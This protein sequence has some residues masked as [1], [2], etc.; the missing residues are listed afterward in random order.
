MKKLF[1]PSW[2]LLALA[3]FNGQTFAAGSINPGR[4]IQGFSYNSDGTGPASGVSIASPAHL[5]TQLPQAGQI[6]GRNVIVNGGSEVA[7]INGTTLITPT[8][9]GYPIDNIMFESTTAGVFQSVKVDSTNVGTYTTG[10][11]GSLGA[12]SALRWSVLATHGAPLAMDEFTSYYPIEGLNFSRFQ[13]GTANAKAGSLQ[14][15]VRCSVSGTYSG[16]VKNYAN[17]RSYPFS[18]LC[19]AGTDTQIYVQNI[20][21]DTGG[22]WIGNTNAG[23]AYIAFDLG[24]G[25]NFKSTEGTWQTG[26]FNGV[27]G[28]TNLSA[29]ANGSTLTITD[30]QFEVM[31]FS[32]QF[33]RKLYD[34]NL[35]ESRRYLPAF[36][37]YSLYELFRGVGTIATSTQGYFNLFFDV[38]ARVVPT[39]VYQVGTIGYSDNV[40]IYSTTSVALNTT[41][42]AAISSVNTGSV[43]FAITGGTAGRPLFLV[44]GALGAG[45]Y[46][47]GCQI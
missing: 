30:V 16:A 34:R 5:S 19:T 3:L 26:N 6:T 12:T 20:P 36:I 47:T 40:A 23:A 29:Q 33:E 14:F 1:D 44:G 32:T 8:T 15:K 45:I 18:Y 28:S 4:D 21:G 38:P 43:I 37:G 24:S 7:Q 22:A 9:G 27:T 46:F 31:A 11:L 17:T 2:I 42:T 10:Y 25:A 13:Y 39:G 41:P 35:A